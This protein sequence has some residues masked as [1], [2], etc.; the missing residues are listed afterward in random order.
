MTAA[1]DAVIYDEAHDD[2]LGSGGAIGDVFC[3]RNILHPEPAEPLGKATAIGAAMPHGA[4][5]LVLGVGLGG[6]GDGG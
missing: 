3:D 1:R 4:A 5:A 6:L 2:F